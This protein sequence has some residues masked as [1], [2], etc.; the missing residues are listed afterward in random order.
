[1]LDKL[2]R[3]RTAREQS[4]QDPEMAVVVDASL[5]IQQL[6]RGSAAPAGNPSR[7][8]CPQGEERIR[9][10]RGLHQSEVAERAGVTRAYL[11]LCEQGWYPPPARQAAIAQVLEVDPSELWTQEEIPAGLGKLVR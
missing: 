9:R 8:S 11:S 6:S 2:T 3:W 5:A 1:M 4:D 7:Q 10:A